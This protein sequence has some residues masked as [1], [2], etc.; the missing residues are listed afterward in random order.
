MKDFDL[1]GYLK[2]N[3]LLNE[4]VE[5]QATEEVKEGYG[6][7]KKSELKEKIREEVLEAL[8]AENDD[9]AIGNYEEAHSGVAE[10]E[11]DEEEDAPEADIDIDADIDMEEPAE[12]E[13]ESDDPFGGSDGDV[14]GAEQE[15]YDAIVSAGKA[16]SK[17]GE[18]P[19]AA[20]NKPAGGGYKAMQDQLAYI[21]RAYNY[22]PRDAEF[23]N[24]SEI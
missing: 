11:G 16:F 20:N 21:E 22:P 12:E 24:D 9:P 3:V 8:S 5:E 15:A 19:D 1:K 17:L 2:N 7:M 13:P 14:E 23:D 18:A 6:K 10:A 4:Q